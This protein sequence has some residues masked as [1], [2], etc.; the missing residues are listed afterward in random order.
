MTEMVF[1]FRDKSIRTNFLYE[2]VYEK[3]YRVFK[4]GIDIYYPQPHEY[5][6]S[7]NHLLCNH[8]NHKDKQYP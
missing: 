7:S 5:S 4:I 6:L 2:V 3:L 1:Q 8:L